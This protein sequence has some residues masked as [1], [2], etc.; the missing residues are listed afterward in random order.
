MTHEQEIQEHLKSLITEPAE[1][2]IVDKAGV[3]AAINIHEGGWN[4]PEGSFAGITEVAWDEFCEDNPAIEHDSPAQFQDL[5]AE[6]V[7]NYIY[8]FSEWYFTH[9]GKRNFWAL[10]KLLWFVCCDA[11]FPAPVPV[12]RFVQQL[13]GLPDSDQDGIWGSGTTA[14]VQTHFEGK[15][16]TDILVFAR[17]FTE[18]VNQRYRD[19]GTRPKY[20][21]V[22]PKWEARSTRAYQA[23]V[24][25]LQGQQEAETEATPETTEV[26]EES[27]SGLET[28]PTREDTPDAEPTPEA[29]KQVALTVLEALQVDVN[30]LAIA[31]AQQN[32]VVGEVIDLQRQ[33][34]EELGNA[35]KPKLEVPNL[36]APM[37]KKTEEA[38]RVLKE[39]GG[40]TVGGLPNVFS[41][42]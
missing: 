42:S 35:K 8:H 19:L 10:P 34:L 20:A 9:P 30:S 38:K 32:E 21:E 16:T 40:Q 33:L 15:T 27:A 25:Y 39:D 18:L 37:Q 11:A 13:V 23:L 7:A 28:P 29:E 17:D 1:H 2:A 12:I 26:V 36:G 31:V 3:I 4:A 41:K 14:A 6:I 24:E 5:P 22:A